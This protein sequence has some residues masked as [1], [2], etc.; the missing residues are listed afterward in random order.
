MSETQYNRT[1]AAAIDR[2]RAPDATP[3]CGLPEFHRV[4]MAANGARSSVR[5]AKSGRRDASIQ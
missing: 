3:K 5:H 1:N 4:T 2:P